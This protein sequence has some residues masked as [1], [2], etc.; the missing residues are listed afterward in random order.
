MQEIQRYVGGDVV[1]ETL[2]RRKNC[3]LRTKKYVKMAWLCAY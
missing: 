2:C 3:V 1:H